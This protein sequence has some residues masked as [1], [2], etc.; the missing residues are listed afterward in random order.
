LAADGKGTDVLETKTSAVYEIKEKIAATEV[1]KPTYTGPPP[2]GDTPTA[3]TITSSTHIKSDQWYSTTTVIFSWDVPYDVTSVRV[4][5]GKDKDVAPNV[6]Y[7][8]PVTTRTIKDAE[9][10]ELY[11]RVQFKNQY[12]WGE[13]GTKKIMI[14]ASP[15][16]DFEIKLLT[17]GTYANSPSLSF[18]TKDTYSGI[19]RYELKIGDE[20]LKTLY[21]DDLAGGIFKIPVQ[22]GGQKNVNV[23]VLDK[24]GNHLEKSADLNIPAVV[25]ASAA[26]NNGNGEE[27]APPV[28]WSLERILLVALFFVTGIIFALYFVQKIHVAKERSL[29]VREISSLRDKAGQIFSALREE[30][31]EQ[32]QGLDNKPQLSADERQ[33]VENLKEVMDLSEE[34]LDSEIDNLRRTIS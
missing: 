9:E 14:D 34:I 32:V 20:I 10:G 4:V 11:F 24:A 5:M 12:G 27:T 29:A 8:P 21:P 23:K 7:T 26:A 30:A 2:V 19:D 3:P 25:A 16:D 13:V 18:A 6:V 22:S 1:P 33:L 15:P 17:E 31:E 28:F